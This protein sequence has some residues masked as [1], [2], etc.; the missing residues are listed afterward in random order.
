M[1]APSL[2]LSFNGKAN[3]RR[4][5]RENFPKLVAASLCACVFSCNFKNVLMVAIKPAMRLPAPIDCDAIGLKFSGTDSIANEAVPVIVDR[6]MTGSVARCVVFAY[7][8]KDWWWMY[9]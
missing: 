8:M 2:V 3:S 1:I 9:R 5:F 4:T 6:M 7:A